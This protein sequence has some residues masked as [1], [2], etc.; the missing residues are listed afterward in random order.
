MIDIRA[1]RTRA[2]QLGVLVNGHPERVAV[3]LPELEAMLWRND[4]PSVLVS[5][6][7]SLGLGDAEEASLAVGPPS[8]PPPTPPRPS[9]SMSRAPCPA[10]SSPRAGWRWPRTL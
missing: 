3:V 6:V 8:R 7:E 4:D 5:I 1:E 10:G 2:E 9:G